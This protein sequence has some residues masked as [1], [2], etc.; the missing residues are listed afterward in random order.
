[1][2]IFGVVPASSATEA[3]RRRSTPAARYRNRAR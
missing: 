2:A 3:C 1:M